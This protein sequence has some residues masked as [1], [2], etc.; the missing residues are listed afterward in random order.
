MSRQGILIPTLGTI[1]SQPGNYLFPAWELFIPTLGI[2][3][4]I[5]YAVGFCNPYLQKK[6]P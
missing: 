5:T 2:S 6:S 1:Y 3:C 4:Y